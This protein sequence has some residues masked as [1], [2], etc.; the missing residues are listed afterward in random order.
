MYSRPR[1]VLIKVAFIGDYY[2]TIHP[3]Y[4]AVFT[5]FILVPAIIT[6][7][8]ALLI[9]LYSFPV[10]IS[11]IKIKEEFSIQPYKY[12]CNDVF[13]GAKRLVQGIS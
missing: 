7:W 12:W 2:K 4:L 1:G 13:N 5:G 6:S 10:L 3:L 8:S 9:V 11:R